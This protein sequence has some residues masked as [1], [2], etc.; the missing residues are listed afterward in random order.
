[1]NIKS[2]DNETDDKDIKFW[3]IKTIHKGRNRSLIFYND[4][5]KYCDY[6]IYDYINIPILKI[7]SILYDQDTEYTFSEFVNIAYFEN[8]DLS[9][10]DNKCE[11]WKQRVLY[12]LNQIILIKYY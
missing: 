1:M 12:A 2:Y 8:I 7:L 4:G 5:I 3:M 6:G 9:E 11:N 10:F